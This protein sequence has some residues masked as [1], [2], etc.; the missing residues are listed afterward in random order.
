VLF[1]FKED[2]CTGEMR[3]WA[4]RARIGMSREIW[5]GQVAWSMSG[6]IAFG[7]IETNN[8]HLKVFSRA[9]LAAWGHL[10]RPER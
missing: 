10:N 9:Y 6:A 4:L 5:L 8:H 7:H 1:W 3:S 2:R